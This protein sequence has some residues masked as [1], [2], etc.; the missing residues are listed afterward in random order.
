MKRLYGKSRA[1]C[2]SLRANAADYLAFATV[3]NLRRAC[4]LP[5]AA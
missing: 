2:C 5:T 4:I 3:C 1:R